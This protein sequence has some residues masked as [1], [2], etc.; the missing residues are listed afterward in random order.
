VTGLW[1]AAFVALWILVVLIGLVVLGMVRRVTSLLEAAEV[2]LEAAARAS[3]G[4]LPVGAMVPT[5]AAETADGRAATEMDL[6]RRLTAVLFL[7]R[8]CDA[9]QTMVDDLSRGQ[10]PSDLGLRLIVVSDDSETAIELSSPGQVTVLVDKHGDVADAFDARVVPRAFIVGEQRLVL[11][12][13]RPN[14]WDSLR[15]LIATTGGGDHR[16]DL[17][18]APMPL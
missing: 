5:F 15:D 1:V 16:A 4:G 3:L 13:G 14:D 18:E 9:C 11:A 10:V 7:S 6:E 17:I 2:S 12:S 8:S